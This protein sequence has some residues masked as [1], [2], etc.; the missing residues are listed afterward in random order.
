MQIIVKTFAII[1]IIAVSGLCLNAMQN[2]HAATDISKQQR[3]TP[4]NDYNVYAL[5]IPE[6]LE[7]AGEPVPLHQP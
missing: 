4:N 7:F 5:P 2:Y 6:H 1:G 3:D